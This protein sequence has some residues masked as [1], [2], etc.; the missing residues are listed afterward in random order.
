MTVRSV[1]VGDVLE[2]QRAP[3]DIEPG[4][5]YQRIGIY[6][7]GKGMMHRPVAPGTE[8]GS[9]RYFRFPA[10]ALVLSNI[11]AWEAAIAVSTEAESSN[12]ICSN[13]FL[14]YIPREE[15]TVDIQYVWHYFLSDVGLQDLRRASPGTQVRNRTLGK[16]LFEAIEVPLP[17][18][19]EQRRIAAH[20]DGISRYVSRV[21]TRTNISALRDAWLAAVFGGLGPTRRLGEVAAVTRGTTLRLSEGGVGAIG[22]ASVRWDGVDAGRLKMVDAE[23]A[24]LQPDHKRVREGD[25]LLNSTG[26]GTI[27][28]ACLATPAQT[29]LLTDSKVLHVRTSANLAPGFLALYLRSPE[30]RAAVQSAKG[31]NT[32]NQTELGL[33]RASELRVPVPDRSAQAT[34]I[35]RWEATGPSLTEADRLGH[36]RDL[37]LKSVLPAGRNEIFSAMR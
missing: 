28:R 11:Q 5:S 4:K 37:L 35:S 30:G 27:G 23:W 19:D 25:V 15:E 31:A 10:N 6:S 32:T 33:R 14:P 1:R 36:R 20:L 16:N 24:G 17:D 26:E 12:F 13:R 29:G 34:V 3:V 22:Q 2:L 8:M 7:W 9:M 18:I 21:Q